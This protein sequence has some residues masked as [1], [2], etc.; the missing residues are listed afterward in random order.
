MP[1]LVTDNFRVFAA[2]QFIESLEEPYDNSDNPEAD[3]SAA[4]QNYRSKIY[5]F[6]GR[7]QDWTLERYSGQSAVTEQAPPDAYDSFNDSNEVYDDMIAVKRI[8]S[9]D[10]SKVIKRLTWKTG[11]K[12][13]MYKND[14][15]STNLSLNGH[16]N[17]YESQSY[18][19]NSNFQVY[20]CI[21]NGISPT[22][23]QGRAST[24]EPSGNSTT[25]I[26]SNADGYRWKYMYTINISDY[27]RFVSSDFMP[28][29]VDTTVAAAAVD[30]AVEQLIIDNRGS[31]NTVNATYYCPV[32][33]DGTTDAIAKIII[34]ASGGIETVEMERV[35]AGYTRAKV[36]LTEGYSSLSD[37]LSRSGTTASIS[38]TVSTIISPPGGHGA[39]PPLE[40]GGY[41]VMINKSLDFLD[42]DGDIPVD[43]QF[44]RFGLVSDPKNVSNTDLTADTATACYAM[45]FPSATN[46]NFNIGDVI[47]QATTGAKGRVIHWDSIT[48]VLRYYQNEHIDETQTG[49]QQY[50]LVPFSG[51]NAVTGSGVT[52]TPDTAAS[53]TGNFFGITFTSGYANPEVKK[54]SGNI[55]YV[56]NRKA[57]NRSTDQ[58][59][60]IKLVVEF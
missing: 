7:S 16:S 48:K 59:E 53:G 44:R 47:T 32:V 20:K 9:T 4:A 39:N 46:V 57:V 55:I 2:E 35:G 52:A 38:G 23:P 51:S 25:I 3:S 29:R 33:G 1:S 42:G 43:T 13:D 58:T 8:K 15:T 40:L 56:E 5:L 17:L 11:I 31:G 28:V 19:V 41:R 24:V 21:Y 27:I 18:V 37:A 60:D 45:K 50:K 36:L 34:N 12:Y 30:G 22:Y 10:V 6:I 54:N 14:Y 49:Q 26:E